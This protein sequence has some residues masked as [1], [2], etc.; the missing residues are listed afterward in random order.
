ME[1]FTKLFLEQ[2]AD[3]YDAEQR[4][5]RVLPKWMRYITEEVLRASVHHHLSETE[6]HIQRLNTIFE[7]SG[8]PAMGRRCHAVVGLIEDAHDVVADHKAYPSINAA[9]ACSLQKIEHY[10]IASYSCLAEW[11]RQLGLEE[12]SGLLLKTLS[13]ERASEKAI[14][15]FIETEL[16]GASGLGE[17]PALV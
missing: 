2:L 4:L 12:A 11:A 13:E 5:S 16:P 10:E 17:K 1:R 15:H 3:I 14:G 6:F 9:I 7:M 8:K